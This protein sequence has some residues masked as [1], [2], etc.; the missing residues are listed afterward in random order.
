MDLLN[1]IDSSIAPINYSK[2]NRYR[3]LVEFLRIQSLK[4]K[5]LLV[6]TTHIFQ[7]LW[8]LKNYQWTNNEIWMRVPSWCTGNGGHKTGS[9]ALKILNN[10]ARCNLICAKIFPGCFYRPKT[11]HFYFP[12]VLLICGT[13]VSGRPH[14]KEL[15]SIKQRK[16]VF[17]LDYTFLDNSLLAF[18]DLYFNKFVRPTL[19]RQKQSLISE[20]PLCG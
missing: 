19:C 18:T 1:K 13:I 16:S 15:K 5:N 3:G 7:Y 17:F 9:L 4:N 20:G 10:A 6:H 11:S 8:T 12:C 14:V 2:I